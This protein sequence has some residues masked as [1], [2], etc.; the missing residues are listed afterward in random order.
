MAVDSHR[1]DHA[2]CLPG[3]ILARKHFSAGT[4]DGMTCGSGPAPKSKGYSSRVLDFGVQ[5]PFFSQKALRS[6]C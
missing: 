1:V 2:I 3:Q 6:E 4:G 5:L